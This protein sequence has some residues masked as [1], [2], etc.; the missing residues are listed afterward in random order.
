MVA[1]GEFRGPFEK[2]KEDQRL[3]WYGIRYIIETYV[4][5]QWTVWDVEIASKFFQTHN[6][7]F[8]DFPFPKDL[9]M[10]V[11][12]LFLFFNFFLIF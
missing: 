8:T 4:A 11:S 1:Y 9:F 5:R 7:G 12:F 2:D 10:K 6:A 3:V